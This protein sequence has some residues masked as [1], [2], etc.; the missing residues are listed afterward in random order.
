MLVVDHEGV[1]RAASSPDLVGARYIPP[2]GQ[3]VV[4]DRPNI[5]VTNVRSS[6]GDRAFRFARPIEY[7]GRQV[8]MVDVSLRRTELES[9]AMLTLMLLLGLVGVM[10]VVVAGLTIG[11]AQFVLRPLGRLKAAFQD[12]ANGDLDFR[13]SHRQRDEFGDLFDAF[14]ALVASVQKRIEGAVSARPSA[15]DAATIT[16]PANDAALSPTPEQGSQW[17]R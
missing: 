7:A 16:E 15:L 8:G 17:S 4:R 10:L 13:I 5:S 6:A 12:A 11:A 2:N 3:R 1:I 9:A 14:N